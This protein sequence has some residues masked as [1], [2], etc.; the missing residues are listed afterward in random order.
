LLSFR[1]TGENDNHD[2]TGQGKSPDYAM[3]PTLHISLFLPLL[4]GLA[5]PYPASLQQ[6]NIRKKTDAQKS[7]ARVNVCT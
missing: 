2:K 6:A 4:F 3:A 5:A 1:H 7:M